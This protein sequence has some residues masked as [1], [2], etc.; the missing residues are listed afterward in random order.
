MEKDREQAQE[1]EKIESEELQTVTKTQQPE[2]VAVTTTEEDIRIAEDEWDQAEE[3]DYDLVKS[4]NSIESRFEAL[5]DSG[6]LDMSKASSA[7]I[8]ALVQAGKRLDEMKKAK[9]R[10]KQQKKKDQKAKQQKM[11]LEQ[12]NSNAIQA[13]TN[14]AKGKMNKFLSSMK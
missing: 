7:Q 11:A 10:R 8:S 13:S 12:Q 4:L 5:T 9:Y 2:E 1:R 14:K 3:P 6:R